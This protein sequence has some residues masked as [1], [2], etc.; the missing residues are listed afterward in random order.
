[1]AAAGDRLDWR[2][3]SRAAITAVAS[4]GVPA[5]L[6]PV[7]LNPQDLAIT[8]AAVVCAAVL[9]YAVLAPRQWMILFFAA[10]T[11]LPPLPVAGVAL[12]PAIMFGA[13]G[14]LAGMVRLSAF[15]PRWRQPYGLVNATLAALYLALLFSLGFA[16]LYSGFAV[17]AGSAMRVLLFGL[18]VYVYF[19]ASQGP[20]RQDSTEA[21]RTARVLFYIAICAGLF[22]CLD[23]VYQ[24]PAVAPFGAQFLW[25]DSGVYRRAQGLFYEASTLGNFSAFFLVMSLV[26][27]M[28][29]RARRV[30]HPAL[31]AVGVV[32][33]AAAMV[34]SFSRSSVVGT[35]AACVA[36]AILEGK[37]W[38]A[39]R[40][41]IIL[42]ALV[43]V[44]VCGLA[45]VLPE[46][47]SGYWQH[48]DLDLDS[49]LQ[50]PDRLL[51]GRVDAWRTVAGFIGDRP[52]Q[53]LFSIGYKTL[54][55]SEYLGR[56]IVADN[57]YLSTFVET[58]AAG[59][60]ALLAFNAAVLTVCWRAARAGTFYGKWMF[61]FWVGETVQMLSADILTYWRV[62]PL[63]FWVLAQAVRRT[64]LRAGTA[65]RPIQ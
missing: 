39:G 35:C 46:I 52:W 27:L 13:A 47:A 14:L 58:G 61:C 55:N 19:S 63:Y 42:A 6:L 48:F 30:L 62:L 41:L 4:L 23:F 38:R 44:A 16:L 37:R 59:L 28:Q 54:P 1:V 20:D 11:L 60:A 15:R 32:L 45:Y 8:L 43:L 3:G 40:S 12:H 5:G 33:F 17:A 22:A 49:I 56:P 2:P 9:A 29:P 7:L 51:S 50:S 34:L 26:A 65:A 57:M 64:D 31:A 18:S 53:V 24:F 36:L 21:I 10:L 25:L